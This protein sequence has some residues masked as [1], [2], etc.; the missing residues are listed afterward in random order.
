[1]WITNAEHAGVFFVFANV[2][3]DKVENVIF[4]SA[5]QPRSYTVDPCWLI[6]IYSFERANEGVL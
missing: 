1:M 3:P 5:I 2:A 6:L 4:T